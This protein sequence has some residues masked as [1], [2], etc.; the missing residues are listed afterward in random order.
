MEEARL[1]FEA[2]DMHGFMADPELLDMM[3]LVKTSNDALDVVTLTENQHSQMLAWCLTPN[4]GHGL[5]DAVVK[6]LLVAAFR[7]AQEREAAANARFHKNWTPTRVMTSSFGS[8]FVARETSVSAEKKRTRRL[9]L[10]LVDIPNKVVVTIEHKAGSGFGEGQLKAYRKALKKLENTYPNFDFCYIVLDR[11]LEYYKETA[12]K[13]IEREWTLLDYGWLQA[14]ARRARSHVA[15][16]NEAARLLMAYCERLTEWQGEAEKRTS[17]LS[18]KLAMRHESVVEQLREASRM[19]LWDFEPKRLG[20]LDGESYRFY[21]QNRVLCDLLIDSRGIA[22]V[23]TRLR[24]LHVF[25]AGYDL[26]SYRTRLDSPPRGVG[27]VMKTHLWPVYVNVFRHAQASRE[28]DR[29]KFTV[30]GML[31]RA[32]FKDDETRAALERQ[33]QNDF[34]ELKNRSDAK[35][36]RFGTQRLLAADEAADM[37]NEH[38]AKIEKALRALRAAQA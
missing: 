16:S 12:R 17:Q 22:A 33:L 25:E 28:A 2:A 24:H 32:A 13:K 27:P 10:F 6:D 19:S 7:C 1:S 8:A 23:E 37:A 5:G 4:E 11:D 31:V 26:E 3:E 38:L 18:A 29:S 36:R 15:R 34:P 21:R 30:R 9:D 14:A 20:S 35:V